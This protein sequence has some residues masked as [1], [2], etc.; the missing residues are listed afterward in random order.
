MFAQNLTYGYY[1]LDKKGGDKQKPLDW[2]IVEATEILSDG[3]IV[4]VRVLLRLSHR[5]DELGH[6]PNELAQRDELEQP[7]GMLETPDD[8]LEHH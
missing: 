7:D 8:E 2:A 6:T 3:S 4:P 1:S 5:N